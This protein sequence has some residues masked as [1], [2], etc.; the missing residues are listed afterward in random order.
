[1]SRLLS[2]HLFS[3]P[4][5]QN[6]AALCASPRLFVSRTQTSVTLSLFTADTQR[7][8]EGERGIKGK[9]IGLLHMQ[10]ERKRGSVR[11]GEHKRGLWVSKSWPLSPRSAWKHSTGWWKCRRQAQHVVHLWSCLL[12]PSPALPPSLLFSL[13]NTALKT[14]QI[15]VGLR[16]LWRQL[17]CHEQWMANCCVEGLSSYQQIWLLEAG[18]KASHLNYTRLIFHAVAWLVTPDI[19]HICWNGKIRFG[20]CLLWL[21]LDVWFLT[22]VKVKLTNVAPH[23]VVT[24]TNVFLHKSDM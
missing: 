8:R 4:S 3:R 10:P 1:M 24:V 12:S 22:A 20:F 15:D 11:R 17:G 6:R 2:S 18:K 16:A 13:W 21:I 23:R 9:P 14:I 7:E 19:W 5:T